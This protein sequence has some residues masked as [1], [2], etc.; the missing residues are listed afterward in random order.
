MPTLATET[1]SVRELANLL[2]CDLSHA[3][4]LVWTGKVGAVK[5]GGRWKVNR[6]SAMDYAERRKSRQERQRQREE[7]R[8]ARLEEQ[9]R[10]RRELLSFPVRLLEQHAFLLRPPLANA[11]LC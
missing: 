4:F 1:N 7:K 2:A 9:A 6:A 3:Y 8:A 10:G 5:V 11:P